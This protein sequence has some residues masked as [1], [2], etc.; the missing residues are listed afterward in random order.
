MSVAQLVEE[1][2]VKLENYVSCLKS[3]ALFQHFN[4]STI[5][6]PG[7]LALLVMTA[8]VMAA[9]VVN[10]G[11]SVGDKKT[12]PLAHLNVQPD[13]AQNL[14]SRAE[15]QWEAG[16]HVSVARSLSIVL[17][18]EPLTEETHLTALF[19]RGNA[20]L[21]ANDNER[22][23]SDFEALMDLSYPQMELVYLLHAM[24]HEK[25]G[26][27]AKAAN[28]YVRALQ[29]APNNSLVMKHLERF[30]HKR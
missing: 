16:D 3:R 18:I 2:T 26:D 22:A 7:L 20:F 14:M 30:F 13:R 9:Q 28:S 29:I 23:I 10:A 27:L 8:L 24:A 12:K 4:P 11:I 1:F 21:H 25:K 15:K 17:S 5:T 19:N 6:R